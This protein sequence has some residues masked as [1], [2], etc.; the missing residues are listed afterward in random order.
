MAQITQLEKLALD[1]R[2]DP[3]LDWRWYS[4]V[5]PLPGLPSNY[6]ESIDI[7]FNNIGKGEDVYGAGGFTCYPSSHTIGSFNTTFYED[8]RGT[9]MDWILKWKSLVKSFTTGFY[10]LPKDYKKDWTVN[11]VDAKNNV[12]M[13]MKLK[14]CWPSAT[15]NFSLNYTSN[16][17]ITLAQEF[18]CDDMEIIN[19]F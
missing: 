12:V 9:T 11:Q 4:P 19:N 15:S 5:L 1:K 8:D 3:L 6:L 7:P 14:G 13:T 16:G 2:P 17:R 18:I 10:G